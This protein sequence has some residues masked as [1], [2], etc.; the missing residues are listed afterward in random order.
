M[1]RHDTARP[2][3]ITRHATDATRRDT[4]R[5]DTKRTYTARP[6]LTRRDTKRQDANRFRL[7]D[8]AASHRWSMI[9]LR[10][11]SPRCSSSSS[12]VEERPSRRGAKSGVGAY[13]SYDED[14]TVLVVTRYAPRSIFQ[15]VRISDIVLFL[16]RG[17]RSSE[18]HCTV[19][20]LSE[21][22]YNIYGNSSTLI[23]M[24]LN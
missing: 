16:L 7:S 20:V 4:T 8:V 18:T 1:T 6:D 22:L 13:L 24:L 17:G 23:L 9:W 14:C 10:Q 19:L 3:D 15:H 21:R 2:S 11:R 5:N 12:V